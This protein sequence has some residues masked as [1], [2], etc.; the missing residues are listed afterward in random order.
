MVE[1][2]ALA[3]Q[4]RVEQLRHLTK[5]DPDPRVRR[6]AHGALLVDRDPP[7]WP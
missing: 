1:G 6:R 2:Q 4:E 5:T 3:Q 7:G